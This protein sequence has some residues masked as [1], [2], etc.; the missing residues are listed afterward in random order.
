MHT[1]IQKHLMTI[2]DD[3]YAAFHRKLIPTVDPETVLGVRSPALKQYAKTLSGTEEGKA[4]LA[5]LPHHYYDEN[6]LHG[7]ILSR[8]KDFDECLTEVN[9]F[10]PYVDNWAVCD[11]LSP[12]VFKRQ[13]QKLLPFIDKWL[14]SERSYTVR[15]AVKCLMNYFLDE[16]FDEVYPRKVAAVKSEEY[17]VNMMIAWYF[18]TALAKQYDA[19][20]PYFEDNKLPPWTHNKAIQKARESRRV[21]DAR[22]AH[23]KTLKI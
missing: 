12:A 4:F 23:L 22:K 10:L 5:E 16:R 15:F 9:R 1:P 13:A 3:E 19:A 7:L 21:S 17:Y 8:I 2:K 18:A 14:A 20:L 6:M 11:S